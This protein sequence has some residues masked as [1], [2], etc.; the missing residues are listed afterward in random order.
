MLVELRNDSFA[1]L[2]QTITAWVKGARGYLKPYNMHFFCIV[3]YTHIM[4]KM[5]PYATY[6]GSASLSLQHK[7]NRILLAYTIL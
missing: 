6:V 2:S 7:P 1:V 3:A 4:Y 5:N